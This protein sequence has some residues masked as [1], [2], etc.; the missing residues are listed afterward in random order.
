MTTDV[1]TETLH[2]FGMTAVFHAVSELAAPWGM[3]VP[4]MPGTVVFHVLTRGSAVIE[5]DDTVVE[6]Q[7]GE[8][9]LVPRGTGHTV[10]DALGSS[11]TPLF[12]LPRVEV[13]DR[14][15][16]VRVPG[17]GP[18]TELVCGAVSFSGVGVGRLVR[19][20]PPVLRAG[21][22][23]DAAWVRASFEVMGA[24]AR[25]PRPGSDV[26]TAR[27]ADVLVVHAV[28]T[29][30]ESGASDQ[31]WVA[32]LRDPVVGRA[33]AAFHADPA[34]VWTVDA[35]AREAGLSR[36]GFA[37]RFTELVGEPAMTYVVGWRM[38]LAAR[39]V[40]EGG[41]PLSRV[42]ERV[43]YRSEAAF[44]RA[45]RRAHGMPPGEFARRSPLF[46]EQVLLPAGL[47]PPA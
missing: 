31:G 18:V 12:D 3:T 44:N 11:A 34:A 28:R 16:R 32:G 20:L 47:T 17:P 7:P 6:L 38:D 29:W 26:V 27:L 45:F 40:R 5:V 9:V 23:E 10:L 46:T 13:G 36:S 33:L 42:A 37:A 39:L 25:S 1:L 22:G 2:D 21:E 43:G 35:L 30:L 15:E 19:S 8:I 4:E 14:Y 41:L 24:E